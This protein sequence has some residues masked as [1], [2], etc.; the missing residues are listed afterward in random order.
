L[1]TELVLIRHGHAV[2]IRGDYFHAP[3]TDIGREQAARTGEYLAASKDP[4]EALYASPLRRAQ[5]TA[6]II[7]SLVGQ[8]AVFRPGLVEVRTPEAM[9]LILLEILSTFRLVDSYLLRSAGRPIHWP[10]EGR[11]SRVLLEVLDRHPGQRV[12]VVVHAGVISASLS[13]F[14]PARRWRW[15]RT[16]VSNCSL[17][18]FRVEAGQVE[19]LAVNEIDHLITRIISTQ[20]PATV[21]GIAKEAHPADKNLGLAPT[22]PQE[23]PPAP[24][25]PGPFD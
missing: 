3:L 17:T 7:G 11:V 19:L 15:W 18:R 10:V 1:A 20:P 25:E 13:W 24:D 23:E 14:L 4:L 9:L 21:V 22:P 12:G 2:R 5:E 6:G 8:A 16:T